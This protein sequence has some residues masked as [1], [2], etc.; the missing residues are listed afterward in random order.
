MRTTKKGRVLNSVYLVSKAI[1]TLI[2]FTVINANAQPQTVADFDAIPPT[3]VDSTTPLVMLVM[4]RDNQL[5]HKAYT[6]YTD[7]DGDGVIDTTYNDSFEYY[8][9]FRSDLCYSYANG[10]FSPVAEVA[11]GSHKCSRQ[12]S[13]NF[14]NWLTTTRIDVVRK[15]LYGGYRSTDTATYTVLQRAFIPADNHAFVKVV[16]GSKIDGGLADY[17]PITGLSIVSFCNVTDYDVGASDISGDM[18]AIDNPPK[19]KMAEGDQKAWSG[20]ERN[21]CQY[22]GSGGEGGRSQFSPRRPTNSAITSI[23]SDGELIVR[24]ETCSTALDSPDAKSCKE[25]EDNS[26]NIVRKPY[27]ILQSYGETGEFRFGLMTG[28]YEKKDRGG[29]LRKNIAL[30]GG[31]D[32]AAADLEIDSETGVFLT[33]GSG[34]PGIIN[35]INRLRIQGWDYGDTHY[36]DCDTYGLSINNFLSTTASNNRKCKDWGNPISELYVEALR[37]FAGGSAN[38]AYVTDDGFIPTAAWTDPFSADAPCS[39]CSIIVLSTGLNNFD[40][41]LYTS[42]LPNLTSIENETDLVGIAEGLN[43][44]QYVVGN[45]TGGTADECDAKSIPSLSAAS[46][47]CPE[48][49]RLQ[50]TYKIAGASYYAKKTDLRTSLIGEQTVN[51]YAVSLSETMP[52]FDITTSSGESVK[53]VPTCQAHSN[54]RRR[55]TDSGWTACSLVDLTVVDKHDFGGAL[56]ISWEDSMWGNDYDMDGYIY[57]EY[58]TKTGTASQVRTACPKG[59]DEDAQDEFGNNTSPSAVINHSSGDFTNTHISHVVP[60]WDEAATGEIQIRFALVASAG[61]NS[62]KFGYVL[63]G[64][65]DDGAHVNELLKEG[66][67]NIVSTAIFGGPDSNRTIWSRDAK[68]VRATPGTPSTLENPLWYAAKYGN[69]IDFNNSNTPDLTSEWDVLNVDGTVGSD[70]IPD[71]YFPVSN[72]ANLP[73]AI[74][75]IFDDLSERVSAGSAAAVNAQTGSGEGAVYQALYAP[76]VEGENDSVTWVGSLHALFID[77]QGRIREDSATPKAQLT[78]DDYVL[79]FYFDDVDDETKIQRFTVGGVAVGDPITFTDEEFSPIWSA[80]EQLGAVT[81]YTVNRSYDSNA[82]SG[83]YI[84]TSFD[85]DG[86]GNVISPVYEETNTGSG[87]TDKAHA[88]VASNFAF[89]GSTATDHGYLGLAS[90][91]SQLQVENLVNFI[92]GEEGIEN[93]RSRSIS[94]GDGSVTKYLIGDIVH[95]T[96]AIVAKPAA[97]YHLSHRD[98][99]YRKFVDAYSSRRNV[100]Y[101]GA[102]DGMLHAFN[103]GFFNSTTT[104]FGVSNT[105]GTVTTHPL[106]SELWGYIPFNLLPHLQWLKSEQYPHVYYMD[107]IVK[108]YDVN[109]FPNDAD[110]PGGW[111]TIIVAGMRFGGGEFYVDHD[112]DETES[113]PTDRVPMRSGYVIL[114]VTNPEVAPKLIAEITHPDLGFS[115]SEPALIK[116]RKPNPSNGSY[117]N[118]TMNRWYLAFGSGPA[119]DTA[120]ERQAALDEAVS[121]KSAKLFI[122]DLNNKSLSVQELTDN[123]GNPEAASFVGGVESVDWTSDFVDDAIYFGLVSGDALTP[124]GKLKRG[125]L[126]FTA[127]GDLSIDLSS[128]LFNDSS[129]P[130]SAAPL[131]FKDTDNEYWVF[132]GSGRYYVPEDN[133][134][135]QQQS[136]FG[137]KEPKSSGVAGLNT[138]V[139]NASLVDTSAID[140]YTDGRVFDENSLITISAD[141]DTLVPETFD[142]VKEFIGLHGGWRFDLHYP[143]RDVDGAVRMRVTTKAAMAGNS[144]VFTAYD[145]TGEYC[146]SEGNGY[147]FAPYSTGG[148]P[149]PFAPVGTDESDTIN[150][151]VSGDPSEERVLWGIQLGIGVPSSPVITGPGS[152]GGGPDDPPVCEGGGVP[153]MALVQKSTG[154]LVNELVCPD[155]YKLGRET[156]REIPVTWE[157]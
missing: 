147:L 23:A 88:F 72:P 98:A 36:D 129:L 76:V 8:G 119:G 28:S 13:G 21:Q 71:G 149:G 128:D 44:G 16:D 109:I 73:T 64:S 87:A 113:S 78:D 135:S 57:F 84:F 37:Y 47:P 4:S 133:L 70:G 52:S 141:G 145:A 26:G 148:A 33:K 103:A 56:L 20:S 127:G 95:S 118:T 124:G 35:T 110:H 10:M 105:T 106:G 116:Y 67:D 22:S 131:A 62:L 92:R 107:G 53:F 2:T 134:S 94:A 7:L 27:G 130:F 30:M 74:K 138:T 79:S 155:V 117:Q 89:T 93:S 121:S 112:V 102:N 152:G 75:R 69:F 77:S 54:G 61:G 80:R 132:A 154:E 68:K 14:M 96:P 108:S 101:V 85:R 126:T 153:Y 140:V 41:D 90:G 39:K 6:D 125:K 151:L 97:G 43:I 146:D 5:W 91:A 34:D 142:D 24:V 18:S 40:G 144:V 104:S 65:D 137:I 58:C 100:I 114:D 115:V 123:N 156:W 83:R 82:S 3:V 86:D 50:G 139:Q 31:V 81:N 42:A 12:W 38:S 32:A 111:G 150:A 136:F 99:T 1:L 11:D 49:P 48:V 60:E 122:F 143:V 51:T 46:G 9:Y 19:L 29:V 55:V 66:N 120:A 45:A 157:M 63:L 17:T 59:L 25:Y 15:V